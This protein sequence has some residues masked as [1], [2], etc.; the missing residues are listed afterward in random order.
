[1]NNEKWQKYQDSLKYPNADIWG[2]QLRKDENKKYIEFIAEHIPKDKKIL[3]LGCADGYELTVL[4]EMGFNYI[5]IT[6]TDIEYNKAKEKGIKNIIKCDIH[7]MPFDREFDAVISKETLE[8]LLS[9]YIGLMEINRVLK[10]DGLFVHIIPHGKEKQDYEYH[11]HCEDNW[12]WESM[13]NKTGFKVNKVGDIFGEKYYI[14]Y[15]Y[16]N[17]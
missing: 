4:E 17:R 12:W 13:F 11:L 9:P 8:H 2:C 14:G 10:K 15:K 5:G 3:V 7:E 1:M 6:L 16:E